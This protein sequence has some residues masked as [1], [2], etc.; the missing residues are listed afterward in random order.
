VGEASLQKTEQKSRAQKKCC[1]KKGTGIIQRETGE[2]GGFGV[3]KKDSWVES[4]L[5]KENTIESQDF[6]EE[7]PQGGLTELGDGGRERGGG[8]QESTV[9]RKRKIQPA[10]KQ[11]IS[12]EGGRC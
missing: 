2:K 12:A 6:V 5:A 10:R 11:V 8:S 1:N 7:N 9:V 3:G 4:T